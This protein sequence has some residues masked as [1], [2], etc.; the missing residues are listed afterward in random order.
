MF[1]QLAPR[2]RAQRVRLSL[3]VGA[4]AVLAITLIG[5]VTA[6]QI[7][8][9]AT[10]CGSVDPTDP[11]N[12]STVSIV[13]DTQDD[14][15]LDHCVGGYCHNYEL[16]TRVLPGGSFKDDAGCGETGAAMTSWEIKDRRGAV[17]GFIAVGS[18]R[19]VTG[20]VFHVRHASRN[21]STPTP[22]G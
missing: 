12:Y 19:S 3:F 11:T 15:I 9:A 6:A 8:D 17:I 16:P 1:W 18:P 14:I 7:R 5:V 22:S 10:G 2:S 4:P 13:N 20:L 21:R